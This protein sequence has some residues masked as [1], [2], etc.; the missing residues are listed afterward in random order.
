MSG[1]YWTSNTFDV[2]VV[3]A[4]TVYTHTTVICPLGAPFPNGR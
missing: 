1:K 2:P 4:I 3:G